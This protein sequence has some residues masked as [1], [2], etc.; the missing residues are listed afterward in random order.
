VPGLLLGSGVDL[1]LH[2]ALGYVGA[3]LLASLASAG[4][5]LVVALLLVGLGA[6][7]VLARGRRR[8]AAAAAV[9]WS[10]ATCPVCLV[11][12]GVPLAREGVLR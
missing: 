1:G 3:G 6:W 2:F 5:V 7:L 12:G 8:G 9:A 11:V 4:W 10:Q